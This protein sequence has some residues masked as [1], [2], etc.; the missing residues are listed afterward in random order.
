[1][2]N[3]NL[4]KIKSKE[5][6][7]PYENLL[8]G[9]ILEETVKFIAENYKDELW[10]IN[11]SALGLSSYKRSLNDTLILSYSGTED[12][13]GYVRKLSMSVVS[14]YMNLDIRVATEFLSQ[15]TVCF[16]LD[17]LKMR[18]PFVLVVQKT[19][20]LST[21]PREKTLMLTLENAKSIH[22]MEYPLEERISQVVFDILDKLELLNEMNEYIDLYD[23]LKTETVE[24]RKVKE[25]LSM[26]CEKKSGFDMKRFEVLRSYGDYAYMKKK[27][28]RAVRQSK[29][30]ELKWEEVHAL[31][32]KFTEPIYKAMLSND[33]FFGDW[34]PEIGRFLD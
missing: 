8:M 26:K 21:F 3:P 11:D 31:I 24:G 7:I 4:I 19:G 12:M 15:N 30:D 28:K 14:Y 34:I 32:I 29:R 6:D 27:W 13:E 17:I 1:M 5:L 22:Y 9:C 10:V 2:L 25:C 33:L 18:I 16:R 23:I 20:E